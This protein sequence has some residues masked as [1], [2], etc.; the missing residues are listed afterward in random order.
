MSF[1]VSEESQVWEVMCHCRKAQLCRAHLSLFLNVVVVTVRL[2]NVCS[3]S[4]QNLYLV[5]MLFVVENR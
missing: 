2:I 4:C 3:Y 1:T 5:F